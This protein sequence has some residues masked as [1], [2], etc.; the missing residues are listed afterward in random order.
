[1]LVVAGSTTAFAIV[2]GQVAFWILSAFFLVVGVCLSTLTVEVTDQVVRYFYR[3][4]TFRLT[5]PTREIASVR[6]DKIG[7]HRG[8]GHSLHPGGHAV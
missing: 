2:S 1:M 5:I 6:S 3:P 4:K 8:L 7:S